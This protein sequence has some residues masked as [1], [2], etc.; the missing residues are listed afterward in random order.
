[1]KQE[2][3]VAKTKLMTENEHNII[4]QQSQEAVIDRSSPD[5]RTLQHMQ[6]CATC[7]QATSTLE[8][9][10]RE[11]TAFVGETHTELKFRLIKNLAPLV[12]AR[13]EAAKT[14]PAG[15]FS[16]LWKFSLAFVVIAVALVAT[17]VQSPAVVPPPGTSPQIASLPSQY[18]FTFSLNGGE[19]REVSLDN[20]VALFANDSGEITLPDR[21][22]L[23]VNG[24]AR[25]TL[26]QRGFHLLQGHVRAEVAKGTEEFSA[27]TPH[28]IITVLGTVFVCETHSRFTTVEVLSGKVRVSSD[29][30]PAV[31]LGPGEKSRM[32]Q[33]TVG[34]TETGTIP[35]LD[36]E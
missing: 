30:A 6:T 36:S 24:P 12:T 28:G 25:L 7:R 9:I 27:T 20:P 32:G 1:M 11:G 31:I 22:R 26:A 3:I 23:L 8:L 21:S 17:L 34:S 4:C 16:W 18:S 33:Q 15:G 29:H 35:S 10:R 13:K 2:R 5:N 14:A 19:P